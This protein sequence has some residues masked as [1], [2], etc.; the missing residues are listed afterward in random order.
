MTDI[1]LVCMYIIIAAC[2]YGGYGDTIHCVVVCGECDTID[3]VAV[4]G[5][6]DTIDCVAVC[7]N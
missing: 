3:C 1:I 2:M 6:C 5:K 4:C 7:G